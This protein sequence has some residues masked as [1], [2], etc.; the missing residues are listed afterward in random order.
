M[1]PTSQKKRYKY[2]SARKHVTCF[3]CDKSEMHIAGRST[4]Q[5]NFIITHLL[6]SEMVLNVSFGIE[7][8]I[9]NGSE[10]FQGGHQMALISMVMGLNFKHFSVNLHCII[11]QNSHNRLKETKCLIGKYLFIL[12]STLLWNCPRTLPRPFQSSSE[13]S[14][15]QNSSLNC[16]ACVSLIHSLTGAPSAHRRLKNNFCLVPFCTAEE[17]NFFPFRIK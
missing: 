6:S 13:Q 9:W 14:F 8:T 16:F 4:S 3:R 15:T 11:F 10:C 1:A 7:K 5:S 12:R 2:W 17:A